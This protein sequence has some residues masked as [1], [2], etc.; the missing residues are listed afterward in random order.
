[1]KTIKNCL[2]F[3]LSLDLDFLLTNFTIYFHTILFYFISHETDGSFIFYLVPLRQYFMVLMLCIIENSLDLNK[4]MGDVTAMTTG[5]RLPRL[6]S[7]WMCKL[8]SS[9]LIK[10]AM[11]RRSQ[12]G[13]LLLCSVHS[14]AQITGPPLTLDTSH[15]LSPSI[16]VLEIKRETWF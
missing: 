14:T 1:M 12:H 11:D 13:V 7:S 9:H 3:Y 6:V 8:V 10:L 15:K 5:P 4:L 16:V 2:P